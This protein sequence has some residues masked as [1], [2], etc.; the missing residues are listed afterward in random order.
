MSN[1]DAPHTITR[2]IIEV[3]LSTGQTVYG[4]PECNMISE[5][6]QSVVGHMK[7]HRKP[8]TPGTRARK[9]R[10]TPT[11]DAERRIAS[12]ERRLAEER[13]RRIMAEQQVEAMV[14]VIGR[15]ALPTPPP[16]PVTE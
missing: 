1:D 4:C 13:A 12:L 9:Q 15:I 5:H 8:A 6:R 10:R 2:H 11:Q 7:A 16:I 14:A 3:T